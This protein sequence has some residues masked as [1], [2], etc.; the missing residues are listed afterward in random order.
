MCC[1]SAKASANGTFDLAYDYYG[2]AGNN[3]RRVNSPRIN[4]NQRVGPI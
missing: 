3:N 2:G 4:H 1:S